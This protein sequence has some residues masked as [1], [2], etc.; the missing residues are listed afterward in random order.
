VE[1]LVDF[2]QR[3]TNI[4]GLP[5]DDRRELHLRSED[6]RPHVEAAFSAP[7]PGWQYGRYHSPDVMIAADSVE[8]VQRGDYL[9]VLGEMHTSANTLGTPSF[10]AQHPCVDDLLQAIERD[11]ASPRLEPLLP[12]DFIPAAR[13]RPG[14]FTS[15]DLRLMLSN[16]PPEVPWD[17]VIAA[18]RLVVSNDDGRLVVRTR[19]RSHQFDLMAVLGQ[20]MTW[21]VSHHFSIL[22]PRPHTPRIIIDRLVVARESWQVAPA[23]MRFA[24]EK[25]DLERFVAARRWQRALGLPR[26]V[27]VKTPVERKPFY[28]DFDSPIYVDMFA[29]A[30]RRSAIETPESVR[31]SISEMLP[32]PHQTWLTDANGVGYTSELRMVA[33]DR[34]LGFSAI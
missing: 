1:T 19:D 14:F 26:Y 27:F 23:E 3:W 6:L 7:M 17:Q 16:D 5:N 25:D 8:H 11:L 9:L 24:E 21:R 33:V 15:R 28:V 29:K 31:V 22:E 34:A 20:I 18:G 4:L 2:T 13:V 10:M 30:M 12:K 32:L